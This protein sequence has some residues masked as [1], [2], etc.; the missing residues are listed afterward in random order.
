MAKAR[1][2]KLGME[3]D[4]GRHFLYQQWWNIWFYVVDPHHQPSAKRYPGYPCDPS[5]A[6]AC[7]RPNRYP[8]H[9]LLCHELRPPHHR[10]PRSRLGLVAMKEAME[11]PARLL[12]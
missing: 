10:R 3:R 7:Q 12:F 8:P 1:D 2:G 11:D 5:R 4:D 6:V 9:E